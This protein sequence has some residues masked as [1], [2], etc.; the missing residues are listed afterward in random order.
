MAAY[1]KPEIQCF[2]AGADLSTHQYKLVKFGSDAK[3]VVLAGDNEE[4]MGVLQNA[5]K[6]GE[7]AEVSVG[8]GALVKIASTVALNASVGSGA[9]GVGKTAAATKLAIG[10]AMD[11]GV[12]GDV[13]P[14][15]IDRHYVPA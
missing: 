5:P 2:Q 10:K 15:I 7:D 12:S 9:S 3:T 11:A 1:L 14:V 6:S 8:G 4:A 13:I